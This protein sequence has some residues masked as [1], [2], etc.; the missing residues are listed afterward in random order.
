MKKRTISILLCLSLLLG[1]I[2][3][4]GL[5]MVSAVTQ[6]EVAGTA[7]S[8]WGAHNYVAADGTTV[9][10]TT[11]TP[12]ADGSVTVSGNQV[13]GGPRIGV[14]NTTP[15]YLDEGGFSLEF[16]LDQCPRAVR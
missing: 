12:N 2:G 3:G 8:G 4:S 10:N 7:V 13:A 6:A 16:S 1:I 11:L 15:I 14:T 5:S 9:V